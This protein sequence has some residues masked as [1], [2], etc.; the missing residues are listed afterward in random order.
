VRFVTDATSISAS[1]DGAREFRMNHMALTGIAGLDLYEREGKEWLYV[2]TGRPKEDYTTAVVARDRPGKSTE[3]LLYLPLYHRVT[4]LHLGISP[5]ASIA[6]GPPRPKDKDRP[7]V[8]YGTSITQG[9][10]ASRTGMCHTA[11]L[12]RWLGREVINL[13]FSGA[14]KMEAELAPLFAEIDAEVF[15]LECLPNMTTEMVVERVEP[16]VRTLR[17]ARPSM[18]ILLSENLLRPASHEQNVALRKAILNLE[19]EGIKGLKL[20]PAAGQLAGRENGTVDG[21]HPTDLGFFR[22]TEAYFPVL[23]DLLK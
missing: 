10:C 1:W 20:M 9:G 3:Y 5:K 6:P 12:G 14:G 2:G 7:I 4:R 23:Q 16:F 18:P 17:K 13:G 8:F 11:I 19:A 15:V 22:M 21:A